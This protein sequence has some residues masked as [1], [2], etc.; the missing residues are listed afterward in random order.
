M[1]VKHISMGT[2]VAIVML[3]LALPIAADELNLEGEGVIH[4]SYPENFKES[5]RYIRKGVSTKSGDC[6]FNNKKRLKPGQRIIIKELAYNP[7]TCESLIIE[8]VYE[9]KSQKEGD[10]TSEYTIATEHM[11]IS[12]S[13]D[14]TVHAYLRTWYDDP[15]YID[16]N[17]VTSEIWWDPTSNCAS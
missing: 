11:A 12:S 9:K 16:V 8:G 1:A 10:V 6:E 4:Y 17:S 5:K 3:F 13:S 2:V 14:W 7:H 15:I